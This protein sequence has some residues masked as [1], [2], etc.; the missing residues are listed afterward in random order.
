MQSLT[1][2]IRDLDGKKIRSITGL[3]KR[4]DTDGVRHQA[5]AMLRRDG[6]KDVASV[7][8]EDFIKQAAEESRENEGEWQ[9]MS[10]FQE[11][12]GVFSRSKFM[13]QLD[14]L[15]LWREFRDGRFYRKF[16][17]REN[18]NARIITDNGVKE[19]MEEKGNIL[20]ATISVRSEAEADQISE[21]FMR[22]FPAVKTTHAEGGPMRAGA[23]NEANECYL[24]AEGTVLHIT[25]VYERSQ[26]ALDRVEGTID[27][28]A[29][30]D[31]RSNIN[32]FIR[33]NGYF[34]IVPGGEL[35]KMAEGG[36]LPLYE[37]EPVGN[38]S[39]LHLAI[40]E[41]LQDCDAETYPALCEVL[42]SPSG[43]QR[44][45][46]RVKELLLNEDAG[47]INAAITQIDAS[48]AR[49][50]PTQNMNHKL[51][52]GGQPPKEFAEEVLDGANY[53]TT[54]TLNIPPDKLEF[55]KGGIISAAGKT[56]RTGGKLIAST[57]AGEAIEDFNKTLD[58]LIREQF[59]LRPDT[60]G[61]A[62]ETVTWDYNAGKRTKHRIL[63]MSEQYILLFP[64][65][66]ETVIIL[67]TGND[68]PDS[69]FEKIWKHKKE[70]AK[71][72]GEGVLR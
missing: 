66:P 28:K 44:T 6:D 30:I 46:S 9:Q 20:L 52:H 56:F 68:T 16:E 64:N 35:L 41:A 60:K 3:K 13:D 32:A 19:R 48:V 36:T 25:K 1:L 2:Y 7:N 54:F 72:I 69:L 53:K 14:P 58:E 18:D 43:Y 4:D 61:I 23:I 51:Q 34:N 8:L 27:G 47:T 12:G 57:Y 11:G 21:L 31:T 17:F 5:L 70:F 42:G 10:H 40:H 39:K 50:Q 26:T 29:F 49:N 63:E 24:D 71:H 33:A 15:D 62:G 38:M 37:M 45:F 65:L 22:E 59:N 67:R 55:R